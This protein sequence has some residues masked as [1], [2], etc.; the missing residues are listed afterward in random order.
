MLTAHLYNRDQRTLKQLDAQGILDSH[1]VPDPETELAISKIKGAFRGTQTACRAGE[2]LWI[3]VTDPSDEDYNLLAE[4][5][6]LHEMVGEDLRTHE[7][8]PKLHDYGAYLYLI[9]H[10]LSYDCDDDDPQS[11]DDQVEQLNNQFSL[12]INEIDCLVGSDYV[13]TLHKEPLAPLEDLKKRWNRAPEMMRP[14]A[15][16]LLYEIM[17]EVL[18]D[19]FPLLD[20]V[21]EHVDELEGRLFLTKDTSV[22]ERDGISGDIFALKR[23]LVQIRRIAGPTRDVVNI[24]LR[25]DAEAGGKQFAYYQDLYD[26]A[27]RIV[28]M[29]DTF[30]DILSGLLD[31][32][33]ALASNRMNE[34]MKTL[35]ATSI[36]LLVP[37]LMAGIY[38]MNFDNMPE[39]HSRNGYFIVLGVMATAIVSLFL[40]FRQKKWL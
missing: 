33:L 6:G 40:M 26:H 39:L 8:R 15:G 1:P 38:G 17:D 28:D 23:T 12:R 34:V 2:L 35:T 36:M 24:L 3:D 5:F 32:Y 31:A 4:R 7:G 37:G 25:R 11:S 9:F 13:L 22:S 19:Y 27:V 16:Y 20:T 14:G 30:R 21:D 10:A 29:T 18:D